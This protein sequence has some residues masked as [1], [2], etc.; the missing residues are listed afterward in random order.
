MT[1]NNVGAYLIIHITSAKITIK[2]SL[3][4]LCY[5]DTFTTSKYFPSDYTGLYI[6]IVSII[7]MCAMAD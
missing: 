5:L 4:D 1:W 2:T 7:N 6:L 3:N